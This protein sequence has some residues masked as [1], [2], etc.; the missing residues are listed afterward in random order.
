LFSASEHF[1]N[2]YRSAK[3][4]YSIREPNTHQPSIPPNLSRGPAQQDKGVSSATE[5]AVGAMA[6]ASR[7][8]SKIEIPPLVS[9]LATDTSV[10]RLTVAN[11]LGK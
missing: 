8:G 7:K 6:G 11:N 2:L 4:I 1:G 5:A 9:S 10:R 3:L